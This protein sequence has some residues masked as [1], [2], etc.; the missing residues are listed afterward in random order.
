[1]RLTM[2]FHRSRAAAQLDEELRDHVER[3]IQ[4]T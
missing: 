1:M 2:L 3:Q 4:E